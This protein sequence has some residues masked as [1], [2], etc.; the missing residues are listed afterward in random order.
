M[1]RKAS[2]RLCNIWL[3]YWWRNEPNSTEV[4]RDYMKRRFDE[5]SLLGHKYFLKIQIFKRA[6]C[7]F[8]TVLLC[9]HVPRYAPLKRVLY[10]CC[11]QSTKT[12]LSWDFWLGRCLCVRLVVYFRYGGISAQWGCF[13]HDYFGKY[14]I[15]ASFYVIS[16]ELCFMMFDL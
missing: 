1:K 10:L 11:Q 13:E 4:R 8:A 2:Q 5:K 16:I 3:A 7:L 14:I 15:H 12:C 9:V 6:C